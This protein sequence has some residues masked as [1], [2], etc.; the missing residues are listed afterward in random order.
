MEQQTKARD[1]NMEL[2][3]ILAMFMV[4]VIH[5]TLSIRATASVIAENYLVS[6][7]LLSLV[8]VANSVFLLITGYYALKSKFN[9]KKVALL[10]GKTIFYSYIIFFLYTVLIHKQIDKVYESLFPVLSGIYWFI[11]AY[12][13]LYLLTP[14]LKIIVQKLTQ[15]QFKYLLIL[16]GIYYGVIK[17]IFN[18]SPLFSGTF[19]Y[20]VFMYL[21][22]AYIYLYV[23][24]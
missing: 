15:N 20:V 19:V 3:R 22:G 17:L 9:I 11:S 4:V 13:A 18:P 24:R 23:R 5:C 2:L 8:E 7:M 1:S 21:L 14:I 16:I 12:I 10:W 6:N